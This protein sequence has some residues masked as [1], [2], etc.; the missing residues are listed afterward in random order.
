MRS[1]LALQRVSASVSVKISTEVRASLRVKRLQHGPGM[2]FGNAK[3]GT[4]GAFRV[5]VA[6][7]PVL[8]GAGADADVGCELALGAAEFFADHAGVWPM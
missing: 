6:L 4:G 3:E 2:A 5:A 1:S 7:L 8:Q